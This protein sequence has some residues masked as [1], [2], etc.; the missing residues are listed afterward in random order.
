MNRT[1]FF[2]KIESN[3]R[4]L[5]ARSLLLNKRLNYTICLMPLKNDNNLI[6]QAGKSKFA[7]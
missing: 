2:Y 6:N 7:T 4:I 5:L 3:F 1:G